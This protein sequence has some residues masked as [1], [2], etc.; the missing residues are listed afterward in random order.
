[1]GALARLFEVIAIPDLEWLIGGAAAALV[2]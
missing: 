1:M 2:S